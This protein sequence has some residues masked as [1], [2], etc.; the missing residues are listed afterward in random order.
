M[1]TA[2]MISPIVSLASQPGEAL[3]ARIILVGLILFA[4]PTT[5]EAE[6][7]AQAPVQAT[8]V[9]DTT[10]LHAKHGEVVCMECHAMQSRHGASLVAE[11]SDCRSCHHT[12]TPVAEDCAG[13]HLVADMKRVIHRV[14]RTFTL[15]VN[16]TPSDR[17]LPFTHAPHG[18]R[19]CVECHTEGPSLSVPELDCQSCHED[20]HAETTSG[21]MS[22]HW[23]PPADA[24]E[25]S[26]HETCSGSGCHVQSPVELS[27]RTRFGCLWCHEDQTDHQLEKECVTCHFLPA[28]LPGSGRRPVDVGQDRILMPAVE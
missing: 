10:F 27:P 1:P 12:E 19:E 22:C 15:T 18:E 28:P 4:W 3:T 5:T 6:T 11:V 7:V 20:H 26:L 25:I 21:C 16:E 2:S 17:E 23:D 13:C 9:A 8:G 14:Q 24:H